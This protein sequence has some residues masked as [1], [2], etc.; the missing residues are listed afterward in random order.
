MY[1]PANPLI[2]QSDFSVLA[3]VH[4]PEFETVRVDLAVFADLEKSPEHIHTYRI[5]PLSLWNAACAG[6]KPEAIITFLEQNAKFPLPD[7]I[8]REIGHYMA[9]YGL[10]KLLAQAPDISAAGLGFDLPTD[11]YLFLYSHD[12]PTITAIDRQKDIRKHLAGR[13]N[14]NTLLVPAGKRGIIKQALIRIGY[15]VEDL[16][17]YIEGEPLAIHLRETTAAGQSFGLRPYQNEAVNIFHANGLATGGSGVL[18]LPCGAGK[19]VIGLGVM[20]QVQTNTLILTTSTTA[21]RQWIRELLDKTSLTPDEVGEYSAD[22]K[23]VRP[24]TVTTYQMI[25]YRPEKDG[26]FPHFQLFNSRPWGFIIYDEVHTLP[27]PV[28][29]VTAELQARRR[30]GLTATLI[31]EDGRETDVFTLIGPKKVDIPWRELERDGWIAPTVCSEL[32]VPMSLDLRLECAQSGD[33]I[34]YR[35][36]AENPAKLAVVKDLIAN[37]QGESILVIGQYIKQLEILAAELNAPL[38]TGKTASAKRDELYEDFRQG[39]IPL[40]VVSKV[41]NFAIDL[42]DASVAIQV[43]GAFGSRQE[44]AQRLGRILRP[45]A[46]GRGAYFYTVVSKDSREQEFSHHRQLFLTEQGYQYIIRDV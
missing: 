46:D 24:I 10:V 9:R 29:Q 20:A 44:E 16:A 31:R 30:L 13:L 27:A 19:T 41:A 18:V 5:T 23:D 4:H 21:V 7:N 43:S 35:L 33:K 22:R 39:R 1:N 12:S 40:L 2:I 38:I 45:K 14:E 34:A 15:P 11:E 3:E 37:H 42:P 25:T 36:E 17:G 28:F 32:R 26:P 6:R 8:R